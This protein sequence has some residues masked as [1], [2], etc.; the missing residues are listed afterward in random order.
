M[1]PL[2][3]VFLL[4][5]IGLLVF[6]V[7][8]ADLAEV[9][10]RLADVGI[11]GAAVVAVVY[12][13]AFVI[14]S[15]S[16]QLILPSARLNLTWL[17][18]MWQVRM[19]GE[20]YNAVLPAASFGGEPVKAVLLK[21]LY[22]VGYRESSAS[23]IM[24]RTINL[25]AFL[26]FGAIGMVFMLGSEALPQAYQ[27][28]IAAGMVALTLGAAGFFAVQRWRGASRLAAWLARRGWGGRRVEAALVHLQD[29]DDRFVGFYR[30]RPG[31]FAAALVL[32]FVNW[33]FFTVELYS[34]MYFL[35]HPIGLGD[36]WTVAA[37]VE[38]VRAGTFFIPANLGANEVAFVVMIGAITGDPSL[39]LAAAAVRR[40]REMLW[41]VWGMALSWRLAITPSAAAEEMARDPDSG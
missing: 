20:A 15:A 19:A 7:A 12:H 13:L 10:A 14:D 26:V 27:P 28:L 38:L 32:A 16:W 24:A 5:G 39:G 9:G 33:T 40:G 37:V 21:K 31:R 25:L 41:V 11:L 30:P 3:I 1:S 18:R 6:V 34:A 2:R 35:G 4:A 29:V 36:A 8:S 17:Y 22:G 23:Q